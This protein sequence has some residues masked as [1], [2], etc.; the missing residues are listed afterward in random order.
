M[1]SVRLGEETRIFPLIRG[2]FAKNPDM[3][4]E[5]IGEICDK[6]EVDDT[7]VEIFY[8][9]AYYHTVETIDCKFIKNGICEVYKNYN[10]SNLTLEIT[11]PVDENQT[12][13]NSIERMFRFRGYFNKT[14]KYP[15]PNDLFRINVSLCFGKKNETKF[16]LRSILTFSNKDE[17]DSFMA[18][19]ELV[20]ISTSCT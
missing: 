2:I 15:Y 12:V 14:A 18:L 16:Y 4:K 20:N 9:Y 1:I 7:L 13:V 19:L 11:A 17:I 5:L 6:K 10:S 3:L 8:V